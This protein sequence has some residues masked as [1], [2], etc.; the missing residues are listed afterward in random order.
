VNGD[1]GIGGA[2]RIF[3]I[4]FGIFLDVFVILFV[5]FSAR[6][7]QQINPINNNKIRAGRQI[8]DAIRP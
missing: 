1:G 7:A 4:F 6:K 2:A 3:V 5:G 8:P